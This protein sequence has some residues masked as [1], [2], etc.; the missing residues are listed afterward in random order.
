MADFED[1]YLWLTWPLATL[2]TGI[3]C[4]V[5]KSE[6]GIIHPHTYMSYYV[7]SIGSFFSLLARFLDEITSLRARKNQT[8]IFAN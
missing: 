5:C 8:Q 2:R 4:A 7:Y 3:G 1:S 6:R